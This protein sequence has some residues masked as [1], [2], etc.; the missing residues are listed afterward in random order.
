MRTTSKQITTGVRST[1]QDS[2]NLHEAA[3]E[4]IREIDKLWVKGMGLTEEP[5]LSQLRV[6]RSDSTWRLGAYDS[7]GT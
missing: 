2:L 3:C 6:L 4:T 7:V 5:L 1:Q